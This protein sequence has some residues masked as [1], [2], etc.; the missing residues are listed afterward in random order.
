MRLSCDLRLAQCLHQF[1]VYWNQLKLLD[2]EIGNAKPQ[3][4][5]LPVAYQQ[6]TVAQGGIL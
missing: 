1:L 2:R 5:T 3:P 6:Y 4:Y